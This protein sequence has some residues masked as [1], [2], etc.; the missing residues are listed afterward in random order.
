MEN[1]TN[2]IHSWYCSLMNWLPIM[3]SYEQRKVSYF[4]T[5]NVNLICALNVSCELLL[6]EGMEVVFARHKK[7]ANA[8]QCAII[9]LGLEL[10]AVRREISALTISAF[11]FP[12]N[13]NGKEFLAACKEYGCIFAGGLHRKI[14]GLYFRVGHMGISLR[15]SCDDLFYCVQAIEYALHKCGYEFERGVGVKTFKEACLNFVF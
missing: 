2:P 8:F 1:R 4:S 6:D 15:E 10:V 3:R 11:Y 5:P 12:A 14:K 9:A 13:V 7:Y